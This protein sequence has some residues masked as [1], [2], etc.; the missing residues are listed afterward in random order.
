MKIVGPVIIGENCYISGEL[1]IG[2]NVS[3]GNNCKITKCSIENSIIMDNCEI[4]CKKLFKDSIISYNSE[5]KSNDDEI[6]R[7]VLGEQ[8]KLIS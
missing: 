4:E 1:K 3:I 8:S 2:P 6:S 5:I 7:L